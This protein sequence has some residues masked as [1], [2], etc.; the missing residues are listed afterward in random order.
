[1]NEELQNNPPNRLL[2]T[3]SFPK[4]S[5]ACGHAGSRCQVPGRGFSAKSAA[6]RQDYIAI[7]GKLA[8]PMVNGFH[9]PPGDAKEDVRFIPDGGLPRAQAPWGGQPNM[10]RT[11]A[12][13]LMPERVEI[14]RKLTV[15]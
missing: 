13:L 4:A 8:S 3:P 9:V 10:L 7:S 15:V 5:N 12:Q 6:P 14:R 2:I 1:M 11:L